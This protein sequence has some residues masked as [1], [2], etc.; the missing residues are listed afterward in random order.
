MYSGKNSNTLPMY[1]YTVRTLEKQGFYSK[2]LIPSWLQYIYLW[3]RKRYMT[4]D[5]T[6][7]S[8]PFKVGDIITGVIGEYN[9]HQFCT[10]WEKWRVIKIKKLHT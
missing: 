10:S 1:K 3:P 5:V 8:A 4:T 9:G 6:L 7:A 2:W